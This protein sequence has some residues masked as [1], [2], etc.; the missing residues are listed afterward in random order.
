[1]TALVGVPDVYHADCMMPVVGVLSS[2]DG[3]PV[4]RGADGG[5]GG[6]AI[7]DFF[8]AVGTMDG[9]FV[10]VLFITVGYFL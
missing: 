5:T 10:A 4:G 7:G 2:V 3:S 8:E 6:M 9:V 1:M